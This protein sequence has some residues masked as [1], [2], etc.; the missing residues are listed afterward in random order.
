MGNFP[1]RTCGELWKVSYFLI[2]YYSNFE[3][4]GIAGDWK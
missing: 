1:D 4:I 2:G 3:I